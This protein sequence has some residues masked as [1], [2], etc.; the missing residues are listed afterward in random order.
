MD[1]EEFGI[2]QKT[3]IEKRA[4]LN[5]RAEAL[6]EDPRMKAITSKLKRL[7]LWFLSGSLIMPIFLLRILPRNDLTGRIK[8]L[9]LFGSALFGGFLSLQVGIWKMKRF[10]W[11][12]DPNGS[13]WKEAESLTKQAKDMNYKVDNNISNIDYSKEKKSIE[14]NREEEEEE[15]IFGFKK[16]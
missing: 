4:E 5:A 2:N 3:E 9:H 7:P 1:D 13:L 10:Y 16:E 15:D 8:P 14:E 12:V 6:M 11:S